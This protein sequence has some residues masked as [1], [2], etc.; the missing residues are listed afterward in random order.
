[1]D[2]SIEPIYDTTKELVENDH[3]LFNIGGRIYDAMHIKIAFLLFIIFCIINT[4]VFA[5]NV[6]GRISKKNYDK[7]QDKVSD[8]G[9]VMGGLFLSAS[10]LVVD[11]FNSRG[12]V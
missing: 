11:L 12:L 1:M 7:V 10:Y 9:I 2:E 8:R 5:E 4:D 6:L 3:S